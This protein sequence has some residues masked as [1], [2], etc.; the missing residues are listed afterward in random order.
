M[1]IFLFISCLLILIIYLYVTKRIKKIIFIT[2]LSLIIVTIAGCYYFLDVFSSALKENC[3]DNRVWKI[4]M[5]E[6]IEKKCLGFSGPY[7]YPVYLYKNKIKIDNI[8]YLSD[9]CIVK[10]K[11]EIGDTLSFDLCDQ[12]L[13]RREK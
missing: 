8:S 1:L 10:F 5:Y 13:I 7:H 6:I 9:S 2:A 3:D 12:T 4:E 11:S